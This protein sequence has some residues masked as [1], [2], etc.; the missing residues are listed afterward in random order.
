MNNLEGYVKKLFSPWT[1]IGGFF[2]GVILFGVLLVL[3]WGLRPEEGVTPV[4]T[5]MIYVIPAPTITLPVPDISATQTPTPEAEIPE[6]P[7][8]GIIVVGSYVQISGTGVDG[9]RLRAAPGL[10]QPI[11]FVGIESEVF[12]IGDGPRVQDDYTWF[13]LIA[14]YDE[15]VRGWAVSNYLLPIQAP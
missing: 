2:L 7:P 15:T 1:F 14:P 6:A 12:R 8:T 3:L 5:S 13:Y 11:K 10:N 4:G 9:L